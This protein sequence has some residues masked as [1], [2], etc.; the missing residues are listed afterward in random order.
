MT[1]VLFM[2]NAIEWIILITDN[3]LKSKSFYKDVLGL[4]VDREI[5][6]EEF[7]QF[8]LNNCF[9]ALYGRTQTEKLLGQKYLN[10]AGGAI[11]TWAESEN[12][13]KLYEELKGKGV[14]FIKPPQTQPWG[15]R[16]AYFTDPDGTIWE[17]QQWVKK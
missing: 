14:T 15:Q 8:K 4:T 2:T 13:D 12:V 9:L 7:V 6:N 10:K 5:D 11:Y 17:I 3:Y 16:T 1:I